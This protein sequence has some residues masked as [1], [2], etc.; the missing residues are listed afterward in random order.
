MADNGDRQHM[1]RVF[2]FARHHQLSD[3][4]GRLEPPDYIAHHGDRLAQHSVTVLLIKM[5][6]QNRHVLGQWRG[7]MRVTGVG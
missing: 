1:T 2:Y 7:E 6:E 5:F 3:D 4:A